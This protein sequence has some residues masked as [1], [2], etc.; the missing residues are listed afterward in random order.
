M[1]GKLYEEKRF[2][3]LADYCLGDVVAENELFKFWN[4]Y[5]NF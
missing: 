5:F 1:V 2:Q 3:E 4:E